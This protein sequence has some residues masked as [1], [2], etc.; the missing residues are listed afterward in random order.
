[1]ANSNLGRKYPDEFRATFPKSRG[2]RR[3]LLDAPQ[4]QVAPLA[5]SVD[6]AGSRETASYMQVTH[7]V[8]TAWASNGDGCED[9]ERTR[10]ANRAVPATGP[11]GAGT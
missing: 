2:G 7:Y 5:R 9:G 1:M 8:S 10:R 11:V 4:G 3:E 6:A